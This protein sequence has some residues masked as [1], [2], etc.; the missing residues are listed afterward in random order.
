[1]LNNVTVWLEQTASK[2]PDKPA[3]C[4]EY[5]SLTYRGLSSQ[6]KAVAMRLIRLGIFKKPIAVFL[7]KGADCVAAFMAAAYSGN[8]Y[9]PVD[10][11]M[12]KKRVQKIL[13]VLDP[14][15]IITSSELADTLQSYGYEGNMVI[16]EEAARGEILEKSIAAIQRK[17]IDTDILYVLFTSGSTGTPKGVAVCHRSVYDYIDWVTDCFKITEE[18]SFGNQ[19]PCYFDNTILDIYSCIKTGAACYIVP[20][21][22]FSQP[23]RLLEY[24]KAQQINTIFWV[25]SALIVVARLKAFQKVN[26]TGILKRVLFCGEVMPNKQLNIWKHYLPDALYA[27]LYGPTEITDAC[28]YYIV[29]RAFSDDEPLPIGFPIPNTDVIVLDEKNHLVV[30]DQSGELCVRGTSLALGYYNNPEKTREAFV[31]NPLNPH[32]PELIYRTG[33]IVKYNERGELIYLA[34]KDFQVKHLGH[35]IELGEIET[36]VSSVEGVELCCCLY[37]EEHR[38]IVLFLDKPLEKVYIN[39]RISQLVPEYMFPNRVIYLECFP[40]NANGKIDRAA[41]KKLL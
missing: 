7:P 12:P 35:R 38:K 5:K 26:L 40:L 27:N 41:L 16:F 31:Q 24:I 1:M 30:G 6:A 29:D 23:V 21:T 36:A 9:T 8:F 3:F 17:C 20:K 32:V 39:E 13:E 25:P 14:K 22:L 19:A 15:A 11:D 34:R 18:D 2:F 10:V 28:T 33:D 4:D 37:D